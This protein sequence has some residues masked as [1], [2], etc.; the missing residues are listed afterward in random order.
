MK[1]RVFG[2]PDRRQMTFLALFSA[3]FIVRV[4]HM[5]STLGDLKYH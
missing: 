2:E 1:P 4:Y 3:L 5:M